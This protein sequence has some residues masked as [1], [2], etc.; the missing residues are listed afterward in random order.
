MG[1][2]PLLTSQVQA[3]D[4]RT[5][6]LKLLPAGAQFINDRLLLTRLAGQTSP[7]PS[8]AAVR[9]ALARVPVGYACLWSHNTVGLRLLRQAGFNPVRHF[10]ALQCLQR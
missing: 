9:A 8:E 4:A 3:V 10:D 5:Y 1:A 7:M 6:Y 2:V